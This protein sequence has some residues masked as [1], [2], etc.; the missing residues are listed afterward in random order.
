MRNMKSS[1]PSTSISALLKSFATPGAEFRGKP[2]WAWNGRL[3]P[4]KLRRQIR[5]MRR[6][7]LG[8]FFMHSRVG[9][10]TPYLSPAWFEAVRACV[11]E[12]RQ[13]GMEAWLYDEDRWPSGAAGGLVT[14]D[15]RYRMRSLVCERLAKPSEFHWTRDTLAAFVARTEGARARAVR[16]IP[17]SGRPTAVSDGEE[18]FRFRVATQGLSPWYNGQTY[19]DTLN[20]AAVRA[21]L[22]IT[23]DAYARRF[24]RDFGGV[25]PGIF[26]DEPNYGSTALP[27]E[28]RDR[29][30]PSCNLPWT[31]ALPAVF[32]R[33]YGYDVIP[34]LMELVFDVEDA[35]AS[36]A[37]Y[38]YHDCITHLFVESFSRQ[39]GEWCERHGL[40]FTGH[41]LAE[42]TLASQTDVVGACMR[43][44][45][46]M[47]A[48]GMDL[49]TERR[50]EYL[51][52]KQV[53][54]AARQF[55]RKW[56]LTETYGCTGWDFPFA[57]HKALGDWQAAL[58]INLRC[59]HLFWYTMLAEAKR[60]YPAD[61][62]PASPWWQSYG[63]VED[64]FAR[65]HAV[66]TRGVEARDALVIH[67]VESVWL[68][69]RAG[70]KKDPEI[71]ALDAALTA[72]SGR[73]L[74]QHLDFDYG[75][76]ELLSR[77]AR[78]TGTKG[79]PRL[80]V[81]RA[82]YRVVVVPAMLTM[83]KTTLDLLRAFRRRGGR[84]IFAGAPA[85]CVDAAPSDEVA[86]FAAEGPRFD[87]P[88]SDFLAAVEPLARRVSIADAEGRE[89]APALYLLREDAAAQYLFVCNTGERF[90]TEATPS[91]VRD[92]RLEFP[93]ARVRAFAG[94]RG[95][96]IELDPA[97]GER[98]AAEAERSGNG[99]LIR[100]SLP[101]LGSRLWIA[102]K[103]ADR[104]AARLPRRAALVAT[105]RETLAEGPWRLR[106]DEP[107]ALV[108][109]RCA[110]S[111]ANEPEA[112]P[113]DVLEADRRIRERMGIPRRGGA[114]AQPWA[115]AALTN[116]R[117]IPVELRFEFD[118]E[119]PPSGPVS[120]GIERPEAFEILLNGALVDTDA[121]RGWWTDESLRLLPLDPGQIRAGRNELRLRL[122]YT[123]DFSGLEYLYLLGE[124][125]VRV[126]GEAAAMTETPRELHLGDWCAQGLPFYGGNVTYVRRL[127]LSAAPG[128]RVFVRLPDYR[129]VAARVRCDGEVAGL[130]AW[131]PYEVEITQWAHSGQEI[132][133]G[134][135]IL[136]HRRNSQGPLH[137]A[138]RWPRWTGPYQLQPLGN[139]RIAAYQLVPCGLMAP[140]HL[141]WRVQAPV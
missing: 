139:D 90:D 21:F 17:R 70:W 48:P 97:T 85:G 133:L 88:D 87:A 92:R 135:E 84:V 81:G 77:H 7:G 75:D 15:P 86:R 60:D 74:A 13:L 78:V 62:G 80:R 141:E 41:V 107:N 18:I 66:M 63:A 105:R 40:L 38:H 30:K 68:R 67:P 20:P 134:I 28:F 116:P 96:P 5:Q 71:S 52:A 34:R 137:F 121:D 39:C 128:E 101:A 122:D 46:H 3:E 27:A 110:L 95:A 45:E 109:D 10:A 76:E 11:E 57:G 16:R 93:D 33:R 55:G 119:T 131:A 29:A 56:R 36:P 59:Q 115:R 113:C 102:P 99:W 120:L 108:L 19:L 51:T 91:P 72:L 104:A 25:I 47:Q 114:M 22:R 50:N 111:V 64:Y 58:G 31:P 138:E 83:R 43:F 37:R 132:E 23:H 44:Y 24:G 6:M 124:F 118:V 65:V 54:S 1:S 32:R 136:G 8:G 106:R 100:T 126:E 12:A 112:A 140:P 79:E 103:R 42:E 14:R 82:D 129:G 130:A 89:I 123:E 73:L 35:T 2:F 94:C 4:D 98:F 9:L 53:S 69:V 127:R 26:T 117:S 61:I 125:G 49:L